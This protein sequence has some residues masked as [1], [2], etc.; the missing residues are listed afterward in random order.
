MEKTWI[1]MVV[2]KK[3]GIRFLFKQESHS[4]F[5]STDDMEKAKKIR[6]MYPE[7]K[8]AR[9]VGKRFPRYITKNMVFDKL[10]KI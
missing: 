2:N 9:I 1:V 5:I 8:N 7:L 6:S 3:K 4:G 10:D